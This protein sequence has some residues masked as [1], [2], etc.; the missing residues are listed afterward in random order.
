[1]ALHSEL[2]LSGTSLFSAT[3]RILVNAMGARAVKRLICVTAKK[4]VPVLCNGIRYAVA[5]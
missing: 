5:R 3:T 4:A 1:V 2:I